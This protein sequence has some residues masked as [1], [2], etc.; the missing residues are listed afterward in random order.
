MLRDVASSGVFVSTHPDVIDRMGTKEVL[1]RTRDM[2]WGC[3]T[4]LYT[5]PD[6]MRSAIVDYLVPGTPRVLK[7]IRGHSG[8]GIWKLELPNKR[9]VYGEPIVT[10]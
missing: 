2:S 4:R 3:D 10:H 9:I 6:A 8:G 5:S 1:Y 7:Q